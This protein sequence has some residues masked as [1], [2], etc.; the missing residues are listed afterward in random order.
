M[1]RTNMLRDKEIRAPAHCTGY[2]PLH[3]LG[4]KVLIYSKIPLLVGKPEFPQVPDAVL[5]TSYGA[6]PWM[7][8]LP[9]TGSI[10]GHA[11]S[12]HNPREHYSYPQ[13]S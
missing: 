11:L 3:P 2:V 10:P 7:L 12:L 6:V 1:V 8:G 5:L 13:P 9:K 4:I